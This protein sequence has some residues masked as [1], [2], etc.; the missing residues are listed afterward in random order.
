MNESA[1]M[2]L[3]R[4]LGYLGTPKRALLSHPKG[5]P[6]I[7][8]NVNREGTVYF[9][10]R[11]AHHQALSKDLW[12]V[13]E[14]Q[15]KKDNTPNLMTLVPAVGREKAAFSSIIGWRAPGRP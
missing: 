13:T 15:Q 12:S 5:L 9:A 2:L 1:Y 8:F 11:S 6:S 7:Y 4:D 10:V 3:F 14:P